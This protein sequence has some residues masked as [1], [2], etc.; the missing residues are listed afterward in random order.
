MK[1]DKAL[2]KR[3]T[4][5]GIIAVIVMGVSVGAMLFAGS[6]NDSSAESLKKESREVNAVRGKISNIKQQI[7]ES[8]HSMKTYEKIR[9]L[10]TTGDFTIDRKK[11]KIYLSDLRNKYRLSS[12]S[13]TVSPEEGVNDPRLKSIEVDAR[14]TQISLTF[15]GMSDTH[16]LSF[17]QDLRASMPG[18]VKIDQLTLKRDKA[19]DVTVY[20]QVSR[21]STPEVVS[22]ELIFTWVGLAEKKAEE[23][24]ESAQNG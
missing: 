7:D 20:R 21:G 17:I 23:Q 2:I 3:I 19:L 4:A 1:K 8:G 11:A 10:K 15:G 14:K 12:L 24:S 22:G 16:L 6:L 5:E 9:E 18:F 13:M